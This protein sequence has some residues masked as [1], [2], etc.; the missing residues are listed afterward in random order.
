M[1]SGAPAVHRG[2]ELDP[3]QRQADDAAALGGS[4]TGRQ[5]STLPRPAVNSSLSYRPPGGPS[6]VG[7]ASAASNSAIASSYHASTWSSSTV[8]Q[9]AATVRAGTERSSTSNAATPGRHNCAAKPPPPGS[10][11]VAPPT[12]P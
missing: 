11:P 10:G 12:A 5:T 6:P 1:S 4:A 7:P 8:P 3:G 2:R 9:T